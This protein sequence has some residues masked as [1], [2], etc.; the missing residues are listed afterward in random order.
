[1][2]NEYDINIKMNYFMSGTSYEESLE[3]LKKFRD[4]VETHLEYWEDAC[5][6]EESFN[7]EWNKIYGED[8]EDF[9]T[10][11][12]STWKEMH[13]SYS[14]PENKRRNSYDC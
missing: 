1:M 3:D 7:E 6:D 2:S 4:E 8:E 5:D 14:F 9:R 12:I 10:P 11:S 13:D